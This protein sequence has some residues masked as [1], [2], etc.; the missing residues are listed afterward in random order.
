MKT[1]ALIS[2]KGLQ[3]VDDP[4]AEEVSLTTEGRYYEKNGSY[5]VVYDESEVTGFADTRTTVKAKGGA[6]SVT[7][8]GKYPSMLCFERGQRHMS[9]YQTDF[10]SL[11]VAIR[12]RD[13]QVALD[14]TGGTISVDYDIEVQHA[15]MGTNSLQIQVKAVPAGANSTPKGINIP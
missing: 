14:E 15:Y 13:I 3:Q 7:R 11:T 1:D 10:G 9:L 12:T 6:V 4:E 8:S 2:I 5:Y